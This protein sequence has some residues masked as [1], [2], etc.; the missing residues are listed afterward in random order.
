M[1][2]KDFIV[3]TLLK[4]ESLTLECKL[5]KNEL[6]KSVWET[7]SSFANT[8]GGLILLGVEEHKNETDLAKR[9]EIVGV[10]DPQKII[11]DFWNTINSD[12][13]NENILL[14]KHVQIVDMNGKQVVAISVPQADWRVKP[15]FLNGNPYKGAFKRNSEGDYHCKEREVKVMIRDSSE[16]GNDGVILDKYT[17]DDVDINSLHAYRNVFRIA[18]L[19]HPWNDLADIDFLKMFGAYGTNRA[20]GT[21]GLTVAGLM[22]FGKGQSIRERF[23]N[24]RMDYIDMS[25]IEGDERY[26]YRLTYDGRW[27]NN[28]YQFLRV[29]M[30]KLTFDMPRPFQMEGMQRKD[31]TEQMIAVRE[32]LINAIIH[33]DVFCEASILRVE[34]HDDHLCFR[35]PGILLLPI[36]QVFAG[37]CSKARNPRIQN[38][39]RMIGYGENIGSGFL[40]ILKAWKDAGWDEPKLDNR[41]DLNEVMLTLNV[42]KFDDKKKE[43]DK[44]KSDKK[45]SEKKESEKNPDIQENKKA[46]KKKRDKKENEKKELLLNLI[47]M[48][49][50]LTYQQ[51]AEKSGL[52]IQAVSRSMKKLQQHDIKRVG[53]K[54]KG[55]WIIIA[56]TE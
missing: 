3:Q 41:L 1:I 44:K 12:K 17:M 45:K 48:D 34:K 24:F 2:N 53:G 5:A 20:Q 10:E 46:E 47:K 28:F 19:G 52:S 56:D 55:C 40:K 6:P 31:D 42:P 50:R 9:F 38:M 25:H 11:A 7:Y 22:M 54:K 35:N 21:D 33:C 14:D 27:E 49:S 39:L 8:I 36:E 18:N 13:V 43:N 26:S 16:D 37:G 29:V 51:L 23:S 32:A 15:V 4:G 30:P